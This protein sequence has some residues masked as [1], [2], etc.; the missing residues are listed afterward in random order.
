MIKAV[1]DDAE[2]LVRDR[3]GSVF[4]GEVMLFADGGKSLHVR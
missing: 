2:A 1:E 4:V 3:G